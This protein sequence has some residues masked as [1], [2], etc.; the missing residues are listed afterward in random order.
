[1]D[2]VKNRICVFLLTTLIFSIHVL[3]AGYE[4]QLPAQIPPFVSNLIKSEREHWQEERKQEIKQ[5]V[6]EALVEKDR[7]KEI[8]PVSLSKEMR[9]Y[10]SMQYDDP[11]LVSKKI[12]LSLKDVSVRDAIELIGKTVG[13]NFLVD[14][15]VRGRVQLLS[16]K[17]IP[18]GIVMRHILQSNSPRLA[19][20][21]DHG[22]F[23]ITRLRPAKD[24]ALVQQEKDYLCTIIS[25]E[26]IILRPK[27]KKLIKKLW[28]GII[29]EYVGKPGFYMLFDEESQ[30]IF[31]RGRKSHVEQFK[32]F[33]RE[34]DF[35]APQV[36]I[37]ARF[38]CA[39]KGFEQNIG[40][41]WSGIYNRRASV[42]RGFD[43]IG[44]GKPLSDISNNPQQQSQA[45]LVDWALNFLPTP[46]K[47]ARSLSLPFIFGGNDLNTKRLNLVLNAAED[48]NEIKTILQPSVLTND[49]ESAEILVGENVPIETIVEESVE[50][51]LRNVKTASYKDI[52]IQLKVKPTVAPDKRSVFLD[53]FIENSQQS[54]SVS[55]GQT[56]YPVIRTTRS[57]TRVRLK[58]G[59]TTM[60]SGLI[61]DIKEKYRTGVPFWRSIPIIGLLFRGSRTVTH[62]MQLL[63]FITPTLV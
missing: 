33:L 3:S 56:S 35:A 14:P 18:L 9:R 58:D 10:L 6:K 62:D 32:K 7:K 20:I 21:R 46:D 54:G 45:S 5:V 41:Q 52:G 53:I 30:K 15:D 48:R 59:Q 19:L 27:Q 43:F 61:K 2:H 63:I 36:K 44:A 4:A 22:L 1:M 47:A 38:V 23:R 16:F 8:K 31:C 40:F 25:L 39:E 57:Q 29:A 17:D 50:G 34:M 55:S 12:S 60:I 26:H 49:G 13:F 42:N 11:L 28:R 37:E 51:R 24:I